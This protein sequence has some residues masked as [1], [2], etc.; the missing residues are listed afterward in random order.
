MIN[1][2]LKVKFTGADADQH[3]VPAFSGIESLD[4]VAKSLLIPINY[5]AEK[6]VRHKNFGF[7]GYSL[8][9][10]AVRPGSLDAILQ[11]IL[12]ADNLKYAGEVG[13]GVTST[14]LADYLRA[15]YSRSIGKHAPRHIEKLEE[16]GTLDTGDMGALVDAIAPSVKRAHTVIGQGANNIVLITGDNNVVSFNRASKAYVQTSIKK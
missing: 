15:L 14:F 3:R 4:G 13:I 6:R 8:D 10:V 7:E 2:P 9:L 11:I 5:L 16:E 12:N 1:F